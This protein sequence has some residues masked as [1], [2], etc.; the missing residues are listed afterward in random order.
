MIKFCYLDVVG[1]GSDGG[2]AGSFC[3]E[4]DEGEPS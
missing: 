4:D 2:V 1:G 3:A